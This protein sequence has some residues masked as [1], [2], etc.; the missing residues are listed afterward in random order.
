MSSDDKTKKLPD[1]PLAQILARLDSIDTRLSALEKKVDE[2]LYDTRPNWSA[3]E[4]RLNALDSRLTEMQAVMEKG[5]RRVNSQ[6]D[7]LAGELLRL[8]TEHN[9]LEEKLNRTEQP[10]G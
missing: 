2:R 10:Q 1:D 4:I 8:R 3:L 5:F 9:E 7:H 6:I